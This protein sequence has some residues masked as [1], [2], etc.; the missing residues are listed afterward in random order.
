MTPTEARSPVGPLD[1]EYL[2][3]RNGKVGVFINSTRAL[4]VYPFGLN[5]EDGETQLHT[6][7]VYPLN[8]TSNYV[9]ALSGPERHQEL[10]AVP[11]PTI[12]AKQ[13]PP[14]QTSFKIDGTDGS[15]ST[16]GVHWRAFPREHGWIVG[17]DEGKGAFTAMYQYI[18]ITLEALGDKDFSSL[19]GEVARVS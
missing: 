14:Y 4:V 13:A 9:L 6:F 10:V 15:L 2:S 11:N 18:N 8:K 5:M 17:R 19:K 7:P 16:S 3:A 12:L 1:G